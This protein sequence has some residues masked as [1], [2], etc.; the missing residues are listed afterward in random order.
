[1]KNNE[2]IKDLEIKCNRLL[3]SEN[4]IRF[5]GIVNRLGP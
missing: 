3:E 1:M 2:E 4:L 5:A